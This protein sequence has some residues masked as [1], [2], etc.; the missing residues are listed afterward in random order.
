MLTTISDVQDAVRSTAGRLVPRG[1]GTKPALSPGNEALAIDLAGLSGVL[2]YEPGEFTFTALA[3]TPIS[4]VRDLLI[5]HGQYLPFDPPL[6]KRGATLG[7]NMA[8]GLSGPGRYRFGGVR[9]FILGVR[10]IDGT[11]QLVR[12]GGKVVKNAAGFDLPKLMVGSLGQYGVLAEMSFKVFP[13]PEAYRTVR[14][15]FD[16]LPAALDAMQRVYIAPLDVDALDLTPGE[17]GQPE[18]WVRLGGLSS[19]LAGRAGRIQ[20]LLGSGEVL[21]GPGEEQAWQ[22]AR[23]F[24]WAPL[25][26]ALAKV[27]LSPARLPAFEAALASVETRRRYSLGG[28]LAWV[29]L[30]AE[31]VAGLDS[32]LA[33]QG[34]AGLL[35]FGAAG[36]PLL[37][38]R[39]GEAFNQRVKAALDPAGRFPS[40]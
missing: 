31:Q 40:L 34:L 27:P 23:E 19:V 1:A 37:G 4:L 26:W 14:A 39:A 13:H 30:P 17:A 28:N 6:A 36:K 22:A 24:S 20:A 18:V 12:G 5:T 32:L 25:D 10:F 15:A 35:I 29:A 11:G 3:G 33:R 9:D 21:S 16:A 7:G 38:Q 2:E 8:A